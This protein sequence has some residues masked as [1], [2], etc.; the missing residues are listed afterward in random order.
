MPVR[1]RFLGAV[2]VGA[3][4]VRARNEGVSEAAAA[5]LASGS[6]VVIGLGI[7]VVA[8]VLAFTSRCAGCGA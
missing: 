5:A 7:G 4:D 8:V 3:E 2:G 6:C 1:R